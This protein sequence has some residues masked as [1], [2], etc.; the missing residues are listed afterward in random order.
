MRWPSKREKKK[1]NWS[2]NCKK[3]E[4]LPNS[5]KENCRQLSRRQGK[6]ELQ[7]WRIAALTSRRGTV[8]GGGDEGNCSNYLLAIRSG[9]ARR[10]S[11]VS[12]LCGSSCSGVKV[13]YFRQGLSLLRF[14]RFLP[15]VAFVC[16]VERLAKDRHKS[17]S[18]CVKHLLLQKMFP[19]F[20]IFLFS[21]KKKKKMHEQFASICGVN[22]FKAVTLI[23]LLELF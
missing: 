21:A 18:N 17:E 16:F 22:S 7:N 4:S 2:E 15:L 14:V 3:L 8:G 23:A 19:L 1:E 11:Q 20:W 10:L 9:P 12:T 6:W 13:K 5:W